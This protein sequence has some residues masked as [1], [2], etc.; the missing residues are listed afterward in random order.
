MSTHRRLH[1]SGYV[2]YYLA[3]L[4]GL[5]FVLGGAVAATSGLLEAAIPRSAPEFRYQVE[6]IRPFDGTADTPDPQ[7]IEAAEQRALENV[8]AEGFFDAVQGAVFVAVGVPTFLWHIRR[9]RQREEEEP[10]EDDAP[11]AAEPS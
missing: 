7:E 8:R 1:W 4:I 9:A 6:P 11:G 3:A 5:G 2:Y 10:P